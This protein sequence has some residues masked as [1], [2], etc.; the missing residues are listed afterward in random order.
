[1]GGSFKRHRRR[2]RA[3]RAPVN[4]FDVPELRGQAAGG[5]KPLKEI[6]PMNRRTL[7]MSAVS[8][9][10]LP[11]T[12]RAETALS[13]V[14]QPGLVGSG[15]LNILSLPVLDVSLFAPQ[16][17]WRSDRPYALQVTFLR[18]L[19]AHK[20]AGHVRDE[21]QHIGVGDTERLDLW[22]R[23]L[24]AVLPDMRRSDRLTGVRD[25]SGAVL[26]FHGDRPLGY[27]A[28]SGFSEAFFGICLDPRTSQPGLRQAVL[29]LS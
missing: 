16:S 14:P 17:R 22:K 19:Q 2:A 29:G 23:K 28:E 10:V 4:F 7:C 5:V 13:Y 18:D 11:Y 1:L 15:R 9:I 24:E 25:R 3:V 12:A 27:I 26:F 21:M 20:V 8:A 6:R